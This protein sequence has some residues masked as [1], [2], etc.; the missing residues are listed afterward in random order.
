MRGAV[1][2]MRSIQEIDRELERARQKMERSR[3]LDVIL[4][5]L[6]EQVGRR[7]QAEEEARAVLE[8]ERGDVEELERMSLVSFL[9]RIQGDLESRKAEE[10]REAAMAK[11]RYDAAKW[12]L[13]DLDRR[14]RDFAQEKESLKGLEKQYQAL[15]DEK[16]AVLRS[17]G[18]AQS[19]RLG[20]LA[21]EQE[22]TAGE[23]REIQ[24]AIQAGLAAQRALEEM[25]GDLNGAE[26]WGVWDMVGGGIMSTFAKHGC[27]DDAQDAA[28]EARR[29]LS[30]FRTELADVSSEQ[31][32]DVE[33]GDFAVFA[34][35]FFDGLFADLFVQSR[36]REAQDQVAAVAQRV[37][38]LIVR[39]RD[40]RENLEEKQGQLDWERERLLTAQNRAQLQSGAETGEAVPV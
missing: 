10:R 2:Y 18:G 4:Q 17:Q 33:L 21:Q 38:R 35:Y 11:A 23:L 32:P 36:I 27:L 19:Q 3:K 14:L 39:L 24:E 26:N 1:K 15:L 40:E 8:K 9:A 31:V 34:D 7:R 16:E 28:Y 6:K 22:R 12:D 13:E 30:R 29:A 25:G 20:Q 37:E 5:D